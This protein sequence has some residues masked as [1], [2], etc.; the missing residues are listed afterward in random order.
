MGIYSRVSG[1]SF[2]NLSE[3]MR[4]N[5]RTAFADFN[6]ISDFNMGPGIGSP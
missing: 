3:D 4:N 5:L 6:L 1:L 2:T